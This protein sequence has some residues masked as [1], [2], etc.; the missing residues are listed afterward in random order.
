MEVR[1]V[2]GASGVL[3]NVVPTVWKANASTVCIL[4]DNPR[5]GHWLVI[6]LDVREECPS[7]SVTHDEEAA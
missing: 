3:P 2:A 7:V 5:S 4:L 1:E 6:S